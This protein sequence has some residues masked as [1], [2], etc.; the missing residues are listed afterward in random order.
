MSL[1]HTPLSSPF[2][3]DILGVLFLLVFIFLAP[4]LGSDPGAGWH[5]KT[6]EWI[7]NNKS[8]I[9]NDPFLWTTDGKPWVANQWLADLI[10]WGI[11][12]LGNWDAL[13]I[14]C[15]SLPLAAMIFFQAGIFWSIKNNQTENRASIVY[16]AAPLVLFAL[17]LLVA[18][19]QWIIRPVIFSFALF[20]VVLFLSWF[21]HCTRKIKAFQFNCLLAGIF[22]LWA[23][24]HS[25][26]PLGLLILFSVSFS[27][28]LNKDY[29]QA[30]SFFCSFLIA[31]IATLIN[32]Y[33]IGLHQNIYE[34]LGNSYFMQ[35][36]AEWRSPDFHEVLFKPL[37]SVVVLIVFISASKIDLWLKFL[38]ALLLALSLQSVR[39]ISFLGV[40]LPVFFAQAFY[41]K[42]TQEAESK[43]YKPIFCMLMIL[44]AF[45]FSLFTDKLQPAKF[46]SDLLNSKDLWIKLRSLCTQNGGRIFN[47]PDY[48]GA[49][50]FQL[51]PDCKAYIDDRNELNGEQ[52]YSNFFQY[53]DKPDDMINIFGLA[54]LPCKGREFEN[55]TAKIGDVCLYGKS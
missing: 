50:S 22:A 2:I 15:F 39:Y 1:K 53:L 23:N 26:F 10:F 40:L 36:N 37:A 42:Q 51:Y 3:F 55:Y 48:G 18:W 8:F 17:S 21:R 4:P 32:P 27:A 44:A 14:F 16:K 29:V 54:M 46:S 25:A 49:I 5:L 38:V 45:S 19:I 11:Y 7:W 30:K 52:A 35:L 41:A 43:L 33:G 9:Y 20:S 24:L 31:L 47:H 28:A 13:A 12:S 6:G 34:L